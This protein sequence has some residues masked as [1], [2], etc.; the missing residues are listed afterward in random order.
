MEL[1]WHSKQPGIL[2]T[3]YCAQWKWFSG[4]HLPTGDLFATKRVNV[5]WMTLYLFWFVRGAM[6]EVWAHFAFLRPYH[7]DWLLKDG[8]CLPDRRHKRGIIADASTIVKLSASLPTAFAQQ[9]WVDLASAEIKSAQIDG[10]TQEACQLRLA[11]ELLSSGTAAHRKALTT[12]VNV[13][14]TDKKGSF[15]GF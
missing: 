6:L 12:L 15:E 2:R 8:G 1:R 3:D 7:S 11:A 14:V 9:Q 10:I 4:L 5:L 13:P